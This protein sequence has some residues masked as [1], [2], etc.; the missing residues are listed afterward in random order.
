MVWVSYKRCNNN[1]FV[2]YK[3]RIRFLWNW[4]WFKVRNIAFISIIALHFEDYNLVTSQ[5]GAFSFFISIPFTMVIE[6]KPKMWGFSRSAL[7]FKRK[8]WAKKR[9]SWNCDLARY[10]CQ[11]RLKQLRMSDVQLWIL[12]GDVV[13]ARQGVR[14]EY[15]QTI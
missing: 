1:L 2:P 5:Y 12:C 10:R 11:N 8:N 14:E 15:T 6:T 3:Y 9:A 13:N 7:L 4:W